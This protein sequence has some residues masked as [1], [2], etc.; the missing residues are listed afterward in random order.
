MFSSGIGIGKL[1]LMV[2]SNKLDYREM[3]IP[4]QTKSL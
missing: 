2:A 4:D 1:L 3:E